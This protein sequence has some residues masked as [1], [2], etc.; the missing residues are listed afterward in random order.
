MN[1]VTNAFEQFAE[2]REKIERTTLVRILK[3]EKDPSQQ[4][5][6][7]FIAN[8]L[9]YHIHN[10]SLNI[11]KFVTPG[12]KQ[13]TLEKFNIL[14]SQMLKYKA[15]NPKDLPVLY[16]Y[17]GVKDHPQNPSSPIVNISIERLVEAVRKHD[18]SYCLAETTLKAPPAAPPT[19][20]AG[21]QP[22]P[23][24]KETPQDAA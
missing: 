18:P 13:L 10:N 6:I 1:Q 11:Y 8:E 20:K 12:S 9:V 7:P 14:L 23:P 24:T 3:G 21:V 22:A 17:F 15:S 5:W 2:R 16:N 19:Q 4:D